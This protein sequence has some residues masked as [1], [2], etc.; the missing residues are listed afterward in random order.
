MLLAAIRF[1]PFPDTVPA[2]RELRAAGAAAGRGVELGRLAARAARAHRA[3]ARC[4]TARS[5]SAEV[6]AAKPDPA[7][8]AARAAR[9]RAPSRRTPGTSAT[10]LEADV[11]AARAA[12]MRPVLIDR[13]G[14]GRRAGRGAP[15][16]LT[17]RAAGALCVEWTRSDDERSASFSAPRI[18]AHAPRA[19]RR[20]RAQPARRPAPAQAPPG[21]LSPVPAWAPLAAMIAAFVVAT[22][23][24]L[25]IAAVVEAGGGNVTAGGPPGLVISATLVQDAALIVAA[26]LLRLDV[27]A[28]G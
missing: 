6:G 2:L 22:I 12:G 28:T 15:H 7:I 24:Y 13:D 18:A 16:R 11:G 1:E 8:L 20:G 14:R 9:S 25:V 23:A 27:G 3:C 21:S 17:G 4:S 5:S 10:T 19:A 26:V